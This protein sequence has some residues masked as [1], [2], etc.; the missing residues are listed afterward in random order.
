MKGIPIMSHKS[1]FE[2][3]TRWFTPILEDTDYGP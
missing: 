3:F 2:W 1:V